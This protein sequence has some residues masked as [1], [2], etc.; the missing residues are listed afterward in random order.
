[1]K[2]RLTLIKRGLVSL[3]LVDNVLQS[4]GNLNVEFAE[5][6]VH[7]QW[8]ITGSVHVV[9][10]WDGEVLS[11]DIVQDGDRCHYCE[12]GKPK[13]YHGKNIGNVRHCELECCD[14]P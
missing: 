7:L 9:G 13:S 11:I 4:I 2:H 8:A 10:D 1:M 5:S 12:Q 6:L 3:L 14:E